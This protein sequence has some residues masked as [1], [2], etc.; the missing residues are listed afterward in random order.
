MT[1]C[2]RNTTKYPKKRTVSSHVAWVRNTEEKLGVK[3]L[4]P[5]IADLNKEV[6]MKYGMIM[7]GERKTETT[8]CVFVIDPNGKLETGLQGRGPRTEHNN[9]G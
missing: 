1:G 5:I 7:R 8:R 3:I 2:P 6:A 9:D 4:F